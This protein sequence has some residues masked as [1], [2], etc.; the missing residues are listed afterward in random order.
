MLEKLLQKVVEALVGNLSTNYLSVFHHFLGL[1]R[2][3]LIRL[4]FCNYAYSY[5]ASRVY[6]DYQR[7][8]S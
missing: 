7:V 4:Q 5:S 1:A 6:K 8:F 2:K 3:G